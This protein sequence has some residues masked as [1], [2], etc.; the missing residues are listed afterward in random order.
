MTT[1]QAEIKL[2]VQIVWALGAA[3]VFGFALIFKAI[4]RNHSVKKIQD[5]PKSKVES[6]PQGY[7]EFEG[8]AWPSESTV[9]GCSG[10]EAVYY[11]LQIQ[12]KVTKYHGNKRR[13]EWVTLYSHFHCA[14]F[15]V[16][17]PTG[18]ALI[19]ITNGEVDLPEKN[20]R[21]WYDL[22][23]D[24]KLR[25]LKI[26]EG[27]KIPSFPPST[28]LFGIFAGSYRI[29]EKEILVGNPLYVHGDF[30]TTAVEPIR[31][32]VL[33]LTEFSN[34]VFNRE[35]RSLKNLSSFL[36]K[37]KDGVISEKEAEYGYQF[38]AKQARLK[39]KDIN[40]ETAFPVHG[41]IGSSGEHKLFLADT[42]II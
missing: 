10:E 31:V 40:G 39:A 30:R 21:S 24:E 12:K 13:T 36:D 41:K 15:Y 29:I 33:G 5:T 22:S 6:A 23:R 18:I 20:K 28:F 11:S 19:D 27:K 35:A 14:P 26:T 38:A 37:N 25:V 1:D 8:F 42:K 7:V 32:S 3:F 9:R 17:D 16:V 34:R 4:K 2:T